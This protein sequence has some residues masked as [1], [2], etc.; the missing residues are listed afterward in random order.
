MILVV[1]IVVVVLLAL[2]IAIFFV[3][4]RRRHISTTTRCE[5]GGTCGV[6]CPHRCVGT[7]NALGGNEE[8]EHLRLAENDSFFTDAAET[9]TTPSAPNKSADVD[10]FNPRAK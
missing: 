4:R 6:L 2:G 10:D 7:D 3:L 8:D 5:C 9:P 1:I